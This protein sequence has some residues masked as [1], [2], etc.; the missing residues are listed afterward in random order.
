[1]A[2]IDLAIPNAALRRAGSSALNLAALTLSAST[3]VEMAAEDTVVGS[4]VRRTAGST[5]SLTDTAGGRFKLSGTTIV[6]GATA[7]NFETGATHNITIRET[8]S[9]YDNSPRDTTLA[10]TVTDV[11]AITDLGSELFF[12]LD[13]RVASTYTESAGAVSEWRDRSSRARRVT[14]GT[15]ANQPTIAN[16]GLATAELQFDGTN[17]ILTEPAASIAFS[18][19]QQLPDGLGNGGS[20]FAFSATGLAK[21]TTTSGW[22]IGNDGRDADPD[23]S[24]A[25]SIMLVSADGSTKVVEHAL[26]GNDT[27]QGVAVDPS[28]NHVW[29]ARPAQ[30]L[31]EKID[32]TTGTQI[33]T[34][35]FTSVN[36]VSVHSD[37]TLWVCTDGGL[38]I[39]RINTS[40]TVLQT[41]VVF[42]PPPDHI[43]YDA[44]RNWLWTADSSAVQAHD[45]V[46]AAKV[47][48]LTLSGMNY[49]EGLHVS[50]DGATLTVVHNGSYHRTSSVPASPDRSQ[51]RTYTLDDIDGRWLSRA[52]VDLFFVGRAAAYVSGTPCLF[53]FGSPLV[54]S[55]DQTRAVGVYMPS[56]TQ[57]RTFVNT[58]LSTPQQANATSTTTPT[59]RGLW[60]IQIDAAAEVVRHY[61]NGVQIGSDLSISAIAGG[62]A[63][64]R[65]LRLGGAI[66]NSAP[67]RWT[68]ARVSALVQRAG[69]AA[70]S[71]ANRQKIEGALAW[72]HGLESLLDG[73][74]PWKSARP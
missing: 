26:S 52:H 53:Q 46:S 19:A 35:P 72:D 3:I 60:H 42:S 51:L 58:A 7:T 11:F 9:G 23:T 43:Y 2:G 70:L 59:T 56:G 40:G 39:S 44:A 69:T 10:I 38:T 47:F 57:L 61:L 66:E 17:D 25:P 74:H 13:A 45:V 55:S 1:M 33:T 21:D 20:G 71:L 65:D 37:G 18:T 54:V 14:Q 8:L 62:V 64:L 32:R 63:F 4:I 30:N 50:A 15:G 12:W 31:V 5:L 28:D 48:D 41:V 6:A 16:A 34:V 27:A 73:A 29:V 67:T 68:Q 24:F 49:A 36:G 22:W